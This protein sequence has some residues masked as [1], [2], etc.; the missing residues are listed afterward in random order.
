[1]RLGRGQALNHNRKFEYHL[2]HNFQNKKKFV[3][4]SVWRRDEGQRGETGLCCWAEGRGQRDGDRAWLLG[5]E[6]Q[7]RAEAQ[8]GA[9]AVAV[10]EGALHVGDMLGHSG[11][12]ALHRGL[13]A[14]RWHLGPHM[15]TT[16]QQ[17]PRVGLQPGEPSGQGLRGRV[18]RDTGFLTLVKPVGP[19]ALQKTPAYCGQAARTDFRFK[20]RQRATVN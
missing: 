5:V 4:A 6:G 14:H 9:P 8:D 20:D 15:G 2:K 18:E 12:S 1:M 17:G 11:P 3:H 19:T 10:Q 13:S 16:A 7:S